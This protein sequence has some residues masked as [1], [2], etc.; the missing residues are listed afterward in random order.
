MS[1]KLWFRA[2]A[3]AILSLTLTTTIALA[4][5]HGHGRDKHDRDDAGDRDDE[6]GHGHDHGGYSDHDR[7][8]IRD[9]YRAH[10]SGAWPSEIAFLPDWRNN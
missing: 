5:D 1:I 8:Q 2:G 4:Q 7:E 10:Y 3:T 6:H 9:W